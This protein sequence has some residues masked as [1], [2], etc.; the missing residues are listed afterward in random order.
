[1]LES[2]FNKITALKTFSFIKKR[3]QHRCFPVNIAKFL[4][5]PI[6]KN[7]LRTIAS[8]IGKLMFYIAKIQEGKVQNQILFE[9]LKSSDYYYK[10]SGPVEEVPFRKGHLSVIF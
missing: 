5:T 6:L 9:L 1:M 10:L 8:G 4:S 3:L 2:L 7:N